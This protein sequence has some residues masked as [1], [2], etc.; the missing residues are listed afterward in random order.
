[1]R[2]FK[3]VRR[4]EV[5]PTYTS[6]LEKDPGEPQFKV[7]FTYYV[8]EHM[9]WLNFW[10]RNTIAAFSTYAEA[11]HFVALAESADDEDMEFNS[12]S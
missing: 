7:E 2:V 11:L 12:R 1:M 9:G 8:I 5:Q 3:I 4:S 10:A 6:M